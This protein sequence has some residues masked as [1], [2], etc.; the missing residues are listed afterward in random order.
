[1]KLNWIFLALLLPLNMATAYELPLPNKPHLIIE[2]YGAV[3]EV[4]DIVKIDFEVSV[5]AAN[6][7]LAKQKVDVIVGKAI[8]AARKQNIPEDQI[9]ASKIQAHPQYEWKQ[10]GREYKG[11]NVIRRV[12]VT[13]T[14]PDRYNALVD[15]LLAAGV[16]RLQHVQMDFSKR[17]ALENK[18]MKLALKN[19]R[20][21]AVTISKA[22]DNRLAGIFQVAPVS[23]P[24]IMARL[25]MS[26]KA[27]DQS[28][29]SGLELGKQMLEQRVR[30]VYLLEN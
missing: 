3:E 10:S 18:A 13:L 19:A 22:L 20:Q 26:A 14:E 12:R 17:Q 9:N 8:A 27:A 24:V 11:E 5:I 30:V 2:G 29:P 28:E 16:S 21:Q 25:E 23:Q 6:L 1:M 4:P 7:S 15:G